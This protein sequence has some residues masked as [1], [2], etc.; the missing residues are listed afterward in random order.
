M[1]VAGLEQSPRPSH[2]TASVTDASHHSV[3]K[4]A[5]L[6]EDLGARTEFQHQGLTAA[7]LTEIALNSMLMS[8]GFLSLPPGDRVAFI[9]QF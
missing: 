8:A 1:A 9:Q 3:E 5:A 2:S 7:P 6:H 4:S